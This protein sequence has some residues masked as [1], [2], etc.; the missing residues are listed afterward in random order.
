[1]VIKAG[2]LFILRG[3]MPPGDALCGVDHN[4]ADVGSLNRHMGAE[5]A[6][7]FNS[8]LVFHRIY[9]GQIGH[10]HALTPAVSDLRQYV[11]ST[12]HII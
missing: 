6:E 4:K 1:M 3:V 2:V 7:F 10:I 12:C 5:N 9:G 11:F 8:V